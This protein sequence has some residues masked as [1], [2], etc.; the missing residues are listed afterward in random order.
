MLEVI[1]GVYQI[2]NSFVNLYLIVENDGLTLIDAGIARSGPKVALEAIQK[3]GHQPKDLQRILFT[4]SDPDHTG[5]AAELKRITGANLLASPHE[6]KM[7]AQG[8]AGRPVK[9]PIVRTM[10]GLMM[11]RIAAQ[12]ADATLEDGQELPVLGGLRMIPSP[13]H[14][15]GHLS[16]YSASNNILF[17][18]DSLMSRNGKL[19]FMDGPFTWDLKRG[20]ESVHTQAKLGVNVVCCGHGPVVRG[21]NIVFPHA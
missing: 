13:G 1:A 17:A 20:I 15:P 18:G 14:T 4:H 12:T 3:L 11:P 2:P 16:F 9:N 21:P 19:S 6:A 7:M 10:L 8:L 5:G